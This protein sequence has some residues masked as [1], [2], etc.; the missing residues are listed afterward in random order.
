LYQS[1][2][3]SS[4]TYSNST[5]LWTIDNVAVNQTI[6]LNIT[7]K[8][9]AQGTFFNRAEIWT[10]NEQDIDSEPAN[11]PLID[12]QTIAK[13]GRIAANINPLLEDDN[14][15]T[16]FYVPVEICEGSGDQYDISVPSGYTQIQWYK[17]DVAIAGATNQTLRVT[18]IGKYTFTTLEGTCPA[19]GCCP[20]EFISIDCC[21][22]NVC[23]P[24]SV[25]KTKS[26]KK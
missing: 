19:G 3:S 14:A 6:T 4:G 10:C 23:V 11:S 7:I 13:A 26:A 12:N 1:H 16:C 21:K 5:G 22:P 15:T 20:A 24:Y 8:A 2:V 25:V 17:D 18:T 9:L